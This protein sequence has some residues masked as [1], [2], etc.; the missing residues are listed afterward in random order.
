MVVTMLQRKSEAPDFVLTEPEYTPEVTAHSH[1][2]L[3]LE[4]LHDDEENWTLYREIGNYT[5]VGSSMFAQEEHPYM[6]PVLPDKPR[7]RS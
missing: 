2:G 5:V 3:R 4:V 1:V 7:N 6:V